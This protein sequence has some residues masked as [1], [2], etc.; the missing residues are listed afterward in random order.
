MSFPEEEAGIAKLF[1]EKT[2]KVRKL[3]TNAE[4][5]QEAWSIIKNY[6]DQN[7]DMPIAT[8]SNDNKN[9]GFD[10]N[11]HKKK[12]IYPIWVK[13]LKLKWPKS[14]GIIIN[15]FFEYEKAVNANS[16]KNNTKNRTKKETAEL[17]FQFCKED[18]ENSDPD[19]EQPF[20]DYLD[21]FDLS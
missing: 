5:T 14:S 9:G 4:D 1:R 20:P 21:N 2:L 17:I 12:A 3:W 11:W 10:E 8:S 19:T 13:I 6:L 15:H 7:M 18:L 16:G